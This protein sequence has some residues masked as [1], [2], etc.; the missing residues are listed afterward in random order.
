MI[1]DK[2]ERQKQLGFFC[3]AKLVVMY[4][5]LLNR[6]GIYYSIGGDHNGFTYFDLFATSESD[7]RFI[8]GINMIIKC[9]TL[10]VYYTVYDSLFNAARVAR[11]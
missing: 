10:K 7:L 5:N 8:E 3:P 2:F 11:F 6:Y 4:A 9:E 1:N